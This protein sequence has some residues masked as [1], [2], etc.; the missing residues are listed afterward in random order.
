[1]IDAAAVAMVVREALTTMP[2]AP[3]YPDEQRDLQPHIQ[4][5]LQQSLEQSFPGA[6][7]RT[8]ISVGGTARPN[9]KLLGTSFWPDVEI[10]DGTMQLVAIEA[11][12]IRSQE[13]PSKAIAEAIGQSVIYSIRYPHVFAFVVHY[14]LS[15]D[16]YHDEDM[17]LEKR[18]APS[19]VELIL[20]RAGDA[21]R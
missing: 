2:L 1:M 11:K 8:T 18:L 14:G 15:D 20:R 4:A 3:T 21:I 12:R 5:V 19:N 9:L 16:R 7:L 13:R 6:G 17:A 10:T